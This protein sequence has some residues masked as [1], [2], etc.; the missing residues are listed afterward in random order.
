MASRNGH[1]ETV[2]YLVSIGADYT[3]IHK[4][5]NKSKLIE[6]LFLDGKFEIANHVAKYFNIKK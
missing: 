5:I 4:N 2:K 1:L 3:K 6:L